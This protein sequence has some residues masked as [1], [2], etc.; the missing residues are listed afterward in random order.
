MKTLITLLSSI[1]FIP[2]ID[3]FAFAA[4]CSFS[5]GDYCLDLDQGYPFMIAYLGGAVIFIGI[6]VLCSM[7]Y[8]DF[9]QVCGGVMAKPH[10]RFKLCKLASIVAI[11]YSN[12]FIMISGKEILFLIICLIISLF[13]CYSFIQYIPYYNMRMCNIRLSAWVAFLSAVFCLIIG[14]FFN[15]TDETNSS[16]TMLFYFLTPCLVQISHLAMLKRSKTIA[17]KDIQHLTN[18]YQVEIKVRMLVLKLEEARNK[19]VKSIYGDNE[20]EENQEFQT[21]EAQTLNEIETLYNEAFKKFPNAELLYLWSGLIQLHIFGNYILAI[22]QCFKGIMNANKVDSQYALYHFRR[23]S[24]SF[25]KAHIKDDAYDYELFEKAFQSAQKNDEAVTRSQFYFWAELESKAPKIQKLNKLAGETTKM[26]GVA[27]A[28]YQRLLKLNSKNTQALRMYGWFLSSLNNFSE[29]GQRY[30]NK[31]EMQEEA[32]QK[33][34]NSNV[35]TS[36]TQP[37]SFFDA[38]N[39]ILCVSGDFE[40]IGEIQKANAS[41]C[42]LFGYLSAELIGRNVS[43]IIPSPFSE[44]HDDYIKRY[45]ECGK[46]IVI[47]NHNLVIYFANKSNYI[48]EARLLVKVVPNDAMPPFLS[49]II[50]PTNPNYEAIMLNKDLVITGY[51]QHC[52]EIFDL[53][54]TK[55][56]EQK[57]YNIIDKFEENKEDMQQDEGFEYIHEHDGSKVKLN[58]KLADF[59]IGDKGVQILKV[60]VINKSETLKDDNKLDIFKDSEPNKSI[61]TIVANQQVLFQERPV[62]VLNH[63]DINLDIDSTSSN[64]KSKQVSSSL[65]ISESFS[66]SEEESSQDITEEDKSSEYS[67]ED[68]D[69]TGKID[70]SGINEELNSIKNKKQ[71]DSPSK[72]FE[73]GTPKEAFHTGSESEHE[74]SSRS[75]DSEASSFEKSSSQHSH[76]IEEDYKEESEQADGQSIHSSSKSMNSSM[77]SLAQFNKS[78]KA[79]VSYEFAHTKKYVMRFKVTLILTILVLIIT[80]IVTFAIIDTSVTANQNLTHYV[81]LVGDVRLYTQSLSYYVRIIALMDSNLASNVDRN[82]FFN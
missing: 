37:L 29:L 5:T 58:L 1:L 51:T 9:C 55:N 47:D 39:A 68:L 2:I 72:L 65:K 79:L 17:E 59:K 56:S 4:R 64:S 23:T 10:P 44:L 43:L 16:I 32:Q 69:T 50:K 8:Y 14:Q 3:T 6:I 66:E 38:D 42:Q 24:V 62:S 61:S 19:N 73:A 57:V 70:I 26:I 12:Y 52:G 28:N 30:L 75:S 11:V 46:H 48:F 77:A 21:I 27:K 60:E 54:N 20:E 25:Y 18:P 45:H 81:N 49:A 34:M 22:I 80:S 76:T 67:D 40:T 63:S 13:M 71:P 15:S 41:A 36:L 7:L 53:G 33:N 74:E 35:M 31:A 82:L 78:I